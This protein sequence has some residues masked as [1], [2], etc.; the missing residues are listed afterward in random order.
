MQV[1]EL[2]ELGHLVK[3]KVFAPSRP[4]LKGVTVRQGDYAVGELPILMRAR[5]VHIRRTTLVLAPSRLVR[6][7]VVSYYHIL[8]KGNGGSTK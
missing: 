6:E 5:A 4:D 8:W 7:Y 2:I 1:H 3:T